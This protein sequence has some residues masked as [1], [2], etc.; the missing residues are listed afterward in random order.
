MPPLVLASSSPYRRD[1]L[2]KLR[3]PFSTEAPELDESSLP[4][5][6]PAALAVRL[7]QAKAV[8]IASRHPGALVLGSDQVAH[9]DGER[10][11]KPGSMAAAEAQLSRVSGRLV[12]FL[13]AVCLLDGRD[14]TRRVHLDRTLVHFRLL[15]AAEI[16]RY[17]AAD[18]PWDCAGGFRCERL[19]IALFER[20]VSEDPTAL[21]GLPLI[22]TARFLRE[23]GLEVP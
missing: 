7:A 6:P 14:G 12:E 1:A 8:A 9:Q 13:T 10:L 5:E 4:D 23:T 11:G 20:V 15:Q 21:V 22:A 2:A 18:T 19:G 17:L 3:M 16:A